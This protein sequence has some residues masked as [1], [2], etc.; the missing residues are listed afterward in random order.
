MKKFF[1]ALG[2][3]VLITIV[4]AYIFRQPLMLTLIGSQIAPETDFSASSTPAAPD[5]TDDQ[6]WAALPNLEDP[7]DQMPAGASS[8]PV[9][10]AVFFVHPTSFISKSGWNQPLQDEDANWV[11]DE[12]VLRHQASV[13]NG[14]CDI[15]APRY[16]QATFYSF[17]D[18]GDN[19]KQALDLAYNDV[20]NAFSEFL[21]RIGPDT[22]FILAGHSQGTRHATALMAQRIAN[23]ELMDRMVASYLIGFSVSHDQLGSIPACQNATDV[24]CAIGWNAMDGEGAGAFGDIDNLLCTNPLTW[25]V[26]DSYAEPSLNLG[27]IGYP[28]YGRAGEDE[29]FTNMTVEVGA[30]DAQ[31]IEGQL[32]VQN[33]NSDAFPSRMLGNSMHVYDYSLFHMN[34]RANVMQR[35]NAFSGRQ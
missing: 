15:Y 13:F 17:I 29:D 1:I 22:P 16:R 11:V 5:Y 8:N 27:S 20:D 7:S 3:V 34:L 24:Q 28:T 12:R 25:R 26:D 2:A 32:A 35:I 9:D 21:A 18:D 4:C 6:T 31:C 14:C 33:L 30:A 23:S 19:S 10:V